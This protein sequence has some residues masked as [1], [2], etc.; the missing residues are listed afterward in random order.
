MFLIPYHHYHPKN[1]YSC[2]QYSL[3][4]HIGPFSCFDET[5]S[6]IVS[7][8]VL[9]I[10]KCGV[11][12]NSTNLKQ[13]YLCVKLGGRLWNFWLCVMD[14]TPSFDWLK[15]TNQK[16]ARCLGIILK[17]YNLITQN[18]N[19]P[20]GLQLHRLDSLVYVINCPL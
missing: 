9:L 20:C 18:N 15:L 12:F 8:A 3:Q 17:F 14:N 10:H 5:P 11:H 2:F 19:A 1:I 7:W 13:V 16:P 4:V 6:R